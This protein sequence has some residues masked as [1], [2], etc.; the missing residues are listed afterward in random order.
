LAIEHIYDAGLP[1]ASDV[2]PRRREREISVRI[3]MEIA[4]SEPITKMIA[5]LPIRAV[6][7]M[8]LRPV[9]SSGMA[10][11]SSVGEPTTTS[12]KPSSRTGSYDGAR[13][14]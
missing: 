7:D 9:R 14:P 13:G 5:R 3:A 12:S 4:G 2:F 6:E 10:P 11:T 8:G 1:G